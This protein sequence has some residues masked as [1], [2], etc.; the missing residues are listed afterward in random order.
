MSPGPENEALDTAWPLRDVLARLV[1]IAE[2]AAEAHAC[3]RHGYE[4]DRA[5]VDAARAILARMDGR[6]PEAP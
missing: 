5:A 6:A 2:H 4:E 1:D 3:D